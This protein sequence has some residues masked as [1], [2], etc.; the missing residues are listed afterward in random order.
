MKAIGQKDK[1]MDKEFYI[2]KNEKD[3][4]GNS[5]KDILVEKELITILMVIDTK[6]A[7]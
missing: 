1:E 6:E 2:I 3:M 7:L 5:K 4:K